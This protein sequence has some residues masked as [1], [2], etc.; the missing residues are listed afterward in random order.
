MRAYKVEFGVPEEIQEQING[1]IKT[2]QS[3][4]VLM[5]GLL[6]SG[7]YR[8]AEFPHFDL[9]KALAEAFHYRNQPYDREFSRLLEE[10]RAGLEAEQA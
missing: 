7:Y 4:A 3:P 1:L 8:D 2:T 6:E 5:L 10:F 9:L